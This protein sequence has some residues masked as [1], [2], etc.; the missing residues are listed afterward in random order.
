M[1]VISLFLNEPPVRLRSQ[2]VTLDAFSQLRCRLPGRSTGSARD[3]EHR[4][5]LPANCRFGRQVLLG[6]LDQS[7]AALLA[8]GRTG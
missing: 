6:T 2:K 1:G 7:R 3:A 4:S 5:D 8:A